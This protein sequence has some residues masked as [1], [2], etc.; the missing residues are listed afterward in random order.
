MTVSSMGNVLRI[1]QIVASRLFHEHG[2]WKLQ[3][4]FGNGVG[5][6]FGNSH[7]DQISPC[8]FVELFDRICR[9]RH[10][11]LVRQGLRPGLGATRDA[12]QHHAWYF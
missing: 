12:C 11:V 9:A 4:R 1:G 3:R 6:Q 2:P 5:H 7:H 10:G 8:L